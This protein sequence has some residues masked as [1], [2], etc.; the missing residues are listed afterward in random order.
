MKP[1]KF[2]V[3]PLFL[4]LAVLLCGRQLKASA[5]ERVLYTDS[6]AIALA[7]MA[8]GE[9]GAVKDQVL[10]DGRVISSTAQK[11]AVMWTALNQYD[12][13][14]ADSLIGVI[15][16]PNNFYGYDPDHPVQDDLLSLAYD[17]LNRW[18]REKLG[19]TDV[20]RVLPPD[21][22]YFTGDGKYNYFRNEFKTNV[23]YDW[24]L[25]DIYAENQNEINRLKP[26]CS[27]RVASLPV[28]NAGRTDL[29]PQ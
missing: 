8:W 2:F 28:R 11:A 3:F 22:I 16:K 18:E 5:A 19:E 4:A 9:A 24:R 17:V 7:Q 20:G 10:S 26:P 25:E 21:Y 13:G 23:Y 27:G 1:Y 6:D 14:I 15:A 12:A 29:Y